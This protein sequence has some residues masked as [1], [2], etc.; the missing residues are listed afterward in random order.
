MIINNFRK[1]KYS[2]KQII[3]MILVSVSSITVIGQDTASIKPSS[4]AFKIGLYNFKNTPS[5]ENASQ[6]VMQGGLQYFKGITQHLD[7][8][9]NLDFTKLKYPF[10]ASSRIGIAKTNEMYTAV[11][12]S[13]N[14]DLAT[15]TADKTMSTEMT[16][17]MEEMAVHMADMKTKCAGYE[18]K[19]AEHQ[20]AMTKQ[21][22]AIKML[23]QMMEKI[24]TM[25][26]DQPAAMSTNQFTAQKN[27]D[28]EERFQSM[29]EAMKKLKSN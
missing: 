18:S 17:K 15:D 28:K 2:M 13:V 23:T 20:A 29:V 24:A 25:P 1:M 14:S 7:L 22:E 4:I 21:Q 19:F 3:V 16:K 8:M 11:D 12:A 5:T 9:V 26:V 6:T 27:E 10:Y